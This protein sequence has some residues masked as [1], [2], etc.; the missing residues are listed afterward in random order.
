MYNSSILPCQV[1]LFIVI[2]SFPTFLWATDQIPEFFMY[3]DHRFYY[4]G[5]TGFGK[6]Y[7][8][9]PLVEYKEYSEKMNMGTTG[10]ITGPCKST[11]CYRG[12]QGTWKVEDNT[13]FLLKLKDGCYNDKDIVDME[14]TFGSAYT[15][16]GVKAFWITGTIHL[17]DEPVNSFTISNEFSSLT[18]IVEKG[19]IVKTIKK[20]PF[21]APKPEYIDDKYNLASNQLPEIVL[22]DNKQFYANGNWDPLYKILI[23]E[24]YIGRM[25]TNEYGELE[26]SSCN[27]SGCYRS[28]QGI[29]EISNDTLYLKEVQD[30]CTEEPIFSLAKVFGKEK[31]TSRGVQAFWISGDLIVSSREINEFELK[32]ENAPLIY[33]KLKIEEGVILEKEIESD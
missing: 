28:Y 26:L 14:A 31:V 18:L 13:L 23:N 15:E 32:N 17:T 6:E 1:L 20:G 21:F 7:L 16:H 11:A 25:N 2:F 3:Q 10:E 29:W 22:S 12:Y 27:S 9:Y 5:L 4:N 33:L 24:K 8:L 30:F 19:H